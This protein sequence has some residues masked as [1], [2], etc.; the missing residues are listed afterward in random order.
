MS[1]SYTAIAKLCQVPSHEDSGRNILALVR[2]RL[3]ARYR[4]PWLMVIDNTDNIQHFCGDDYLNQYVPICSHG[5]LL[6][7]TKNKQVAVKMLKGQHFF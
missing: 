3:Q 1:Q 5:L 6:I 2:D 4:R 7:S